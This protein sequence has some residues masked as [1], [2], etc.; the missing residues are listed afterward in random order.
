[1]TRNRAQF[2]VATLCLVAAGL[3]TLYN[4]GVFDPSARRATPPPGA[5]NTEGTDAPSAG[6]LTKDP[7]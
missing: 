6:V 7:M 2:F 1:M 3:I 5:R 4:V